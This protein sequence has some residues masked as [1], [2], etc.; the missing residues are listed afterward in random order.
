TFAIKSFSYLF[1]GVVFFAPWCC[2]PFVL[3]SITCLYFSTN[4][5]NRY[6]SPFE[7]LFALFGFSMLTHG[8][9]HGYYLKK[10]P[11]TTTMPSSPNINPT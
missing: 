1:P 7:K 11:E 6:S 3:H 8:C 9:M 5:M 4:E 10:T 2:T